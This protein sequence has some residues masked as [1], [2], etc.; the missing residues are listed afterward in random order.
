VINP[1][2]TKVKVINETSK[3][4]SAFSLLLTY[5]TPTYTWLATLFIYVYDIL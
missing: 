2:L 4:F 5:Y 3:N 1:K